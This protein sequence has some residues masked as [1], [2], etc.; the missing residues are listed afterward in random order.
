MLL[1]EWTPVLP[2]MIE[3]GA[4][5]ARVRAAIII[6][7]LGNDCMFSIISLMI[8]TSDSIRYDVHARIQQ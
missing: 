8:S 5:F 6:L 7:G 2:S 3:N 1:S 4:T